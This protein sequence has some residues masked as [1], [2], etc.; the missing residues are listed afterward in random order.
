MKISKPENAQG[1]KCDT[2][3]IVNF[4]IL[5]VKALKRMNERSQQTNQQTN[6]QINQPTN[7]PTKH[8]N[9]LILKWLYLVILV[10]KTVYGVL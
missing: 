1:C 4:L 10:Y 9:K 7:Q 6:Q 3:V 2:K 8:T 5:W